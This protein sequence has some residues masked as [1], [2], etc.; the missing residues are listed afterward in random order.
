[1]P[2]SPVLTVRT[3]PLSGPITTLPPQIPIDPEL[4]VDEVH[5][6]WI[7]LN[8]RKFTQFEQ[9]FIDGIQIKYKDEDGKVGV[10]SVPQGFFVNLENLFEEIC[11][12]LRQIIRA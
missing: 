12:F 4:S 2:Q 1:M 7:R 3:L 6:T 5:S 10:A 11:R 9:Q 8:W